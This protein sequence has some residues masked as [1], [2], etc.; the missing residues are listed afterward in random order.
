VRLRRKDSGFSLIEIMVVLGLVG[1]LVAAISSRINKNTNRAIR[2]DVRVFAASL[3]DLRNHA[4]M[5]NLT[6]CLVINM[7]E[8]KDEKQTYWIESTGKH[9]LVTYDEEALKKLKEE[10]E[11]QKEGDKPPPDPGGFEIDGEM[12]K[13]GPQ[14]LPDG[15]F[16]ESVEIAAL[17]KEFTSGRIYVHFFPEGRVEEAVLHI[18]NRDK[19]HWS[20]AIHPLT[21]HVDI[22]SKE[23]KEKDMPTSDVN[24]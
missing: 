16:F 18:G 20:L 10:A 9:F 1:I 5:R 6:Y 3:R 11:A 22:I 23:K 19:L 17:K 24:K 14:Q 2:R 13:G 4:R 7:P 21:G 8:K 15:L 12:S